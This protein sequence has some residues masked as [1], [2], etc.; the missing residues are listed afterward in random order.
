MDGHGIDAA[1]MALEGAE[2]GPVSGPEEREGSVFGGGEEVRAGRED[3][4]RDG[5]W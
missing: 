3:E 4:R 1:G 2:K 5:A